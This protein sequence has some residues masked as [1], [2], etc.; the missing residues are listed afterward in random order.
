MLE[1]QFQV[2]VPKKESIPLFWL[3]DT[4]SQ[5]KRSCLVRRRLGVTYDLRMLECVINWL[6]ENATILRGIVDSISFSSSINLLHI[7]KP[8][9]YIP[10]HITITNKETNKNITYYVKD[11]KI[12]T[13]SSNV[14]VSTSEI[15]TILEITNTL[16]QS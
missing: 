8:E 15:D 6:I 9:S 12:K 16:L 1:N 2:V 10:G 4:N 14:N 7:S 3:L 11:N 5:T 13:I